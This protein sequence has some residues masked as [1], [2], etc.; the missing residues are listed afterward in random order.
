[1]LLLKRETFFVFN[2]VY[3][4]VALCLSMLMPFLDLSWLIVL[5]KIDLVTNTLAVVGVEKLVNNT[6]KELNWV[7][8]VD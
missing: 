6:E 8:L 5:P 3:L 1:M 2:R 4:L 7:T